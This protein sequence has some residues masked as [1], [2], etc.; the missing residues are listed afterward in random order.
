QDLSFY[1]GGDTYFGG[2]DSARSWY[3]D[4]LRMVYVNNETFSNSGYMAFY[5]N[6][7]TPH[8][9]YHA[10]SYWAG[11]MTVMMNGDLSDTADSSFMDAGYYLQWD[12]GELN[13]G[14]SWRIEAFETWSPPGSLQLLTPGDEN[15]TPGSTVRK[16]FK[17]HNL[18]AYTSL[19]LNWTVGDS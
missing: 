12:R 19:S 11:R 10:G 2:D 3:D 15:V 17:I 8:S 5:A 18:S 4:D 7:L 1:H 13:P 16:T 14:E 6:P 9:H